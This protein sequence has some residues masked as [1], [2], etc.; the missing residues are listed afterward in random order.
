MS[1][2]ARKNRMLTEPVGKPLDLLARVE[3][4][5]AHSHQQRT[6]AMLAPNHPAVY[7]RKTH[8]IK[9]VPRVCSCSISGRWRRRFFR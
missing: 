4:L 9:P 2:P 1:D 5:P 7:G 8:E 3:R 6:Q